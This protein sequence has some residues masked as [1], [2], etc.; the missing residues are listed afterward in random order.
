MRIHECSMCGKPI[1][2]GHGMQFVRNDAKV[3]K[4]CNKKCRRMFEN[5]R[6]PRRLK[7]TKAFRRTHNKE[8]SMDTTFDFEK[9]RNRPPK[10]DRELYAQTI[11]A[12]KRVAEIQARRQR[13][14]YMK[15][16]G[17][18]N[19]NRKA[20]I[21]RNVVQNVHL[22]LSSIPNA[23]RKAQMDKEAISLANNAAE[24]VKLQNQ[25]TSAAAKKTAKKKPAQQAADDVM[26]DENDD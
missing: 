17:E 21:M 20:H 7:W 14:F 3:F 8:L 22:V 5:K 12:M 26:I 25:L 13:S 2:P 15:R 11:R 1:Y 4:F 24:Q 18:A 10:Y 6:N 23:A 16:M 9:V 19:K